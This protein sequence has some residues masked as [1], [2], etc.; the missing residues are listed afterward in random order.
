VENDLQKLRID[1]SLTDSRA[2]RTRWPGVVASAL[3]VIAMRG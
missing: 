3:L 1:K 2:T